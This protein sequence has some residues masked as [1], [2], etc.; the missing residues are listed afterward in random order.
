[1][2]T[3]IPGFTVEGTPVSGTTWTWDPVTTQTDV[4]IGD[5]PLPPQCTGIPGEDAPEDVRLCI[6]ET[7]VKQ[8]LGTGTTVPEPFIETVGMGGSNGFFR[9]NLAWL[10]EEAVDAI[11]VLHGTDDPDI[12]RSYLRGEIRAYILARLNSI[13]NLRLYDP[14]RMTSDERRTYDDL[15]RFLVSREVARAKNALAEYERWEKDPCSY[16]IPP[17]P[18]TEVPLFTNPANTAARCNRAYGYQQ[19]FEYAKN[20]PSVEAFEAW[21]TY[22]HPTPMLQHA[23]HPE[24]R[25]MAAGMDYGVA[26]LYGMGGSVLGAGVAATITAATPRLSGAVQKALSPYTRSYFDVENVTQT[27]KVVSKAVRGAT[28]VFGIVGAVLDVLITTAIAI[29]QLVEEAT[30]PQTLRQRH[31]QAAQNDD[32]LGIDALAPSYAGLDM[33]TGERPEGAPAPFHQ[34]PAFQEQLRGI[35]SEWT[36][37]EGGKVR[38]DPETGHDDVLPDDGDVW[39]DDGP[40]DGST[41]PVSTAVVAANDE[42]TTGQPVI[43][44]KVHFSRGH[45]MVAPSVPGGWG[46]ARPQGSVRYEMPDGT[47]ALMSIRLIDPDGAGPQPPQRRFVITELGEERSDPYL[48]DEWLVKSFGNE[49]QT[50]RLVDAHPRVQPALSVV[51]TLQGALLPG[52][53]VV[54]RAHASQAVPVGHAYRWRVDR[55]DDEGRPTTIQ[56]HAQ[57]AFVT[58]FDEPGDYRAVV[59]LVDLDD[60]EVTATGFIE[61]TVAVPN[62]EVVKAELVDE[63]LTHDGNL[64]VDLELAQDTPGDTFDVQIEWADDN[65]GNRVVRDYTVTCQDLGDGGCLTQ[66]L[67]QGP[68]SAPTNQN[69]SASPVFKLPED[70]SFLEDVTVTITN[71][72][73]YR[74]TQSFK[75]DGEH[76]ATYDDRTPYTRMPVG[77]HSEVVITRVK[78]SEVIPDATIGIAPFIGEIADQLPAG[79]TPAVDGPDDQGRYTLSVVGKPETADLGLYSFYF[80]VDQLS[81]G[82]SLPESRPAPAQAVLAIVP[83]LLEGYRA[84]LS[85]VPS[86]D[87]NVITRTGFPEWVV[88]VPYEPSLDAADPTA[89][90]GFTGT[91]VC[92]LQSSGQ[93]VPGFPKPCAVDQPFPFPAG[94]PDGDWEVSVHVETAGPEPVDPTPYTR[95]LTT[96]VLRATLSRDGARSDALTEMLRLKVS[97]ILG[98]VDNPTGPVSTPYSSRGFQVTC[99]FGTAAATRCLDSGTQQVLRTPGPHRVVVRVRAPDGTTIERQLAWTVATP[100]R[101]LQV[102]A[103]GT[104]RAGDKVRVRVGGLLPG[105]RFTATFLG[106]RVRGVAT[107]RGTAVARFTVGKRVR[108]VK[109]VTVRGATKQRVGSDRV[110]VVVRRR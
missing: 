42:T 106:R 9:P 108:G 40:E 53:D 31:E 71:S 36:M 39:F 64:F 2:L 60:Q 55:L 26:T 104:A 75:I 84:I 20:P 18:N 99:R 107:A 7:Y 97:D 46:T 70:Q 81:G 83:T 6:G 33:E 65:R 66:P 24:V 52:R 3:T 29:W 67:T 100:P 32:P 19:M 10:E 22:R 34:T 1:M 62:V 27:I 48:T 25:K 73:G 45:L 88:Q 89:E 87:T 44:R 93:Q 11:N 98:N 61:F 38:P 69:W 74:T 82:I 49:P 17:R 96:R 80:P 14:E 56:T 43:S 101:R 57:P 76:R 103:P 35:V 54:L 85:G 12:L 110:R 90:P 109:K 79:L 50:Y 105:E 95:G 68:P 8:Q 30:V 86:G 4:V 13:L 59:E 51:P 77:V 78:P 21:G 28:L 72:Y 23:T 92:D 102:R 16:P 91:V 5:V 41:L 37:F 15:V 63:R 58:D 94:A 47:P